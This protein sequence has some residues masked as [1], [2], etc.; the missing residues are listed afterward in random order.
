MK[1]IF[2]KLMSNIPKKYMDFI[3][4]HHFDQKEKRLRKYKSS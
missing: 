3:M 4:G 1:D 2:L